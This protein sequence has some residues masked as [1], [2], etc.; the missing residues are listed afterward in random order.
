MSCSDGKSPLLQERACPTEKEDPHSQFV[1]D[2]DGVHPY[3]KA[4]ASEKA[5]LWRLKPC[6]SMGSVVNQLE[7]PFSSARISAL[8]IDAERDGLREIAVALDRSK[9]SFLI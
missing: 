6:S 8:L 3:R 2:L 7:A 1:G 4:R 5:P 9:H